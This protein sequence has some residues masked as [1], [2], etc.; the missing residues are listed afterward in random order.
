MALYDFTPFE[1]KKI[2]A[3]ARDAFTKRVVDNRPEPEPRKGMFRFLNTMMNKKQQRLF[4]FNSS[5]LKRLSH[6]DPVTYSIIRTIKSYVNQAEWDIVIDVEDEERELH[7]YEDYVVSHLSPYASGNVTDFKSD[8]LKPE[9]V[10]EVRK[11]VKRMM[12]EPWDSGEKKKAI[13][14][15]FSSVVR[16]IQQEAET[17]R[18]EVKQIFQRP[19]ER[20]SEC[21]LRALQELVLDDILIFDAGVIV[22]NYSRTGKLAEMYHLPGDQLRIY[23][24]EDRTTPEPPEPAYVWEEDG[25]IRAEYTKDELVYIMQNPQSNG[26][27]MSPI[28]VA[29]YIIT[30]SIYADEYN[31]DYFKN[32]NVP[33]GVFNLG[34]E[35]TEEQ[36]SMFQSM[37]E[38]E[39]RGRGGLHRMLFLSGTKNP[40][41]IPVQQQTNRDMQMMEYMKWSVAVKTAC[42]GLSGQ[43]I[44]FVVDYHRSVSETQRDL[45]QARGIKTVLHLLQQYYTNEIVKKEFDFDDVKFDWQDV[46]VS[47][48]AKTAQVDS[49]DIQN[50]VIT[51]NERRD[52]LGLRPVDGGDTATT[53]SQILPIST[54]EEQE[55]AQSAEDQG[56]MPGEIG[57]PIPGQDQIPPE[58]EGAAQPPVAGAAP[59]EGAPAEEGNATR[60]VKFTVNR[61]VP[62]NKQYEK[63]DTV[64]KDMRDKGIDKTIKINYEVPDEKS[65]K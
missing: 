45:S 4:T 2:A 34:E 52:K 54:M 32:S 3:A 19:S 46:D 47:D 14:W 26:Y 43:D 24:N 40:E 48:E 25:V 63:L 55:E 59:Q 65:E 56:N 13:Q 49:I 29:A 38:S 41:F 10:K 31:I 61:K 44:G 9:L 60:A 50:G 36:R 42:Y 58:A 20:G 15:Y 64:I 35:V 30:A 62:I 1:F 16:R 28:E 7:R 22:K 8:I 57:P 17:H 53:S 11:N 27:G 23:R 51:R 5:T 12:Q 21:T 39:V 33:P 37:W 6:V 18:S